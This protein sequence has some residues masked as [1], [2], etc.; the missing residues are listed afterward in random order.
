MLCLHMRKH[1]PDFL[2]K[3]HPV[4]F[5]LFPLWSRQKGGGST[6]VAT[7]PPALL[8]VRERPGLCHSQQYVVKSSIRPLRVEPPRSTPEQPRCAYSKTHNREIL[9]NS[10][11]DHQVLWGPQCHWEEQVGETTNNRTSMSCKLHPWPGQV[12]CCLCSI[13]CAEDTK[14]SGA[15]Y[16]LCLHSTVCSTSLPSACLTNC[17][18]C[19]VKHTW[20]LGYAVRRGKLPPPSACLRAPLLQGAVRGVCFE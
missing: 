9:P 17:T 14:T 18:N 20:E 6:G 11:F 2:G 13:L 1:G 12:G 3:L 15:L 8:R 7:E 4:P 16:Q 5:R 19:P 10:A